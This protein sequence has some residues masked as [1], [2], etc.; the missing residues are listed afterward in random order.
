[1]EKL[2]QCIGKIKHFF[3]NK[4]LKVKYG[5]PLIKYFILNFLFSILKTYLCTA[6]CKPVRVMGMRKQILNLSNTI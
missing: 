5:K 6:F 2:Y 1:M 4:E 3:R